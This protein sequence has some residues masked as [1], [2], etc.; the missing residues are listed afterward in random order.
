MGG[1]TD[2]VKGQVKQAAGELTGDDKLERE[3][4]KDEAAG[5]MKEA[6][7]GVKDKANDA[8]DSLKDKLN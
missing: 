3:G 4:E 6:V 1:E 5:K 2:Q 7:D 8:I